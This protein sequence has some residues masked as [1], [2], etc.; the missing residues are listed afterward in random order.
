MM[1]S[2][3]AARPN[4]V[5]ED[6]LESVDFGSLYADLSQGRQVSETEATTSRGDSVEGQRDDVSDESKRDATWSYTSNLRCLKTIPMQSFDS[7]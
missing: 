6:L 2:V 7:L 4:D 5:D 3:S 1:S